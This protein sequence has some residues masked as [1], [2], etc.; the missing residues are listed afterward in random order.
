[1]SEN[2][3]KA[4][5]KLGP[6]H[7]KIIRIMELTDLAAETILGRMILFWGWVDDHV[8]EGGRLRI[9]RYELLARSFGYDEKFWSALED[10]A[11]CWLG[12][13]DD[14]FFIP[15][16]AKWFS[17]HAKSKSAN[18]SRQN[19]YRER[20]K[21]KAGRTPRN[22]KVTDVSQQSN[23]ECNAES[24]PDETRRDKTRQDH[25]RASTSCER[26]EPDAGGEDAPGNVLAIHEDGEGTG[27]HEP[28]TGGPDWSD[29]VF[30]AERACNLLA[31]G[32]LTRLP[33]SD[34][35]LLLKGATLGGMF[36][37]A[38]EA[39]KAQ[40]AKPNG[41]RP[42]VSRCGYLHATLNSMCHEKKLTPFRTMLA[43]LTIPD[44]L[45][46]G[47]RTLRG[48]LSGIA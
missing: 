33:A 3:V 16:W 30:H 27:E 43:R 36:I 41:Q 45:L 20:K 12:H 29:A 15:R 40:Y 21:T 4:N 6:K 37:D 8:K 2:W 5:K 7:P 31:L 14:G 9:A 39:T 10:D 42:K 18:A 46:D 32:S 19:A 35:S 22:K 1:M 26:P 44:G 47:P 17:A 11:V 13:D 23:A 25:T 48:A 34:Q 38:V 24:L 28:P